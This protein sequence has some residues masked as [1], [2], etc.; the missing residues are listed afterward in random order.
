FPSCPRGGSRGPREFTRGPIAQGAVWSAFVVILP[1]QFDERTRLLQPLEPVFVQALVAELPVEAFH[2]RI[3]HWFP[4]LN[5]LPLHAALVG[6]TVHSLAG[7][8]RA[9]V[10]DQPLG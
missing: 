6:P 2:I 3:L 1:P 4:R 10:T 9:V 8:L 5:E 7:K